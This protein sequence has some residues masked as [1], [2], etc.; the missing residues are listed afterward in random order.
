MATRQEFSA[1]EIV[2]R[3]PRISCCT[4]NMTDH[5]TG[6]PIRGM[7]SFAAAK[8]EEYCD[9]GSRRSHERMTGVTE[10]TEEVYERRDSI[11]H[12]SRLRTTAVLPKRYRVSR[13]LLSA[14]MLLGS[15]RSYRWMEGEYCRE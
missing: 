3:C 1:S 10:L 14:A 15:M 6:F 11:G 8:A 7:P 2:I 13:I 9:W 12:V 5:P 4:S